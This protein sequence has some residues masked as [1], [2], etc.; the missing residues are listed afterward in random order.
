M[1][2]TSEI[3]PDNIHNT[4]YVDPIKR[5]KNILFIS[6]VVPIMYIM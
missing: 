1:G 3:N 6:V 5:H 4:P 2:T